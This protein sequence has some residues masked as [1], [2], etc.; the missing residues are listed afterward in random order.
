MRPDSSSVLL[1]RSNVSSASTSGAGRLRRSKYAT[2]RWRISRYRSPC[3]SEPSSSQRSNRVNAVPEIPESC[4]SISWV[5]TVIVITSFAV[6]R[7]AECA[8]AATS[9]KTRDRVER[10]G[11]SREDLYL[12]TCSFQR[13]RHR[14]DRPA[15]FAG[16]DKIRRVVTHAVNV[17][18]FEST[19]L[20]KRFD[21]TQRPQNVKR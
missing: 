7:S 15:L 2:S 8:D 3:E 20:L 18:W 21:A 4:R 13:V 12:M 9:C 5:S 17:A 19:V 14:L 10:S 11:K 16:T 1:T 6:F